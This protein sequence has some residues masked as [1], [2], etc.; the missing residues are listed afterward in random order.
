MPFLV[1]LVV[2]ILPLFALGLSNHGLWTPDEPRVGEIGREMALSGDWAVPTLNKRPFLEEP[3]FYYASLAVTFKL[4]GAVSDR[5]A[6]MPS[7]LF[8]FGGVVAL[9]FLGSM[10]FNPR[11]GFL[12]GFVLATGGE[13][14]RVAHWLVVDSAL[15]CFVIAAMAFFMAGYRSG[16]PGKRLLSYILCYI[17]CTLAFYSKGFIGIAIPGLAVLAFII[18]DRNLKELLRMQLWLG[19]LVFAAMVLPW[20]VAL[21]HQGGAEHLRVYLIH[22]HLQRFLS[23]GTSG[24]HQP[25][26]YYLTEFPAGFLPWSLLLVPV[27]YFCI[28]RPKKEAA[29]YQQGLLFAGCW[30][31][32]GFVFLSLASTKRV[33]YLMPVF[34][35]IAMLT[36]CYIDITLASRTFRKVEK[37]FLWA[38]GCLPLLVGLMCVPLYLYAAKLYAVGSSRA[39]L[40]AVISVSV[41]AVLCSLVSLRALVKRQM[42]SFWICSDAALF[43]LLIFALVVAVPLLDRY[44]SLVPFCQQVKRAVATDAAL[45]AY[46]PDETLRG[47]LPFYTGYHPKE[48]EDSK[49]LEDILAGGSQVYVAI[50]DSHQRLEKELLSTGRFMVLRRQDMGTDRS[51]VLLTNKP[52]GEGSWGKGHGS[53][54]NQTTK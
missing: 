30:F 28:E 15:T 37:V 43:S 29:G 12:S 13:Y 26:Y 38:F 47:A 17:S 44:K 24:H 54:V 40:A 41:L 6:R 10:L 50:R 1:L 5:V 51:L 8:A 49:G 45:Y 53:R 16:K 9:F 19:I 36:A 18:F 23:G 7:A 35:P 48:I 21:W 31:L 14:F 27:V 25:F 46:Q 52:I 3:P 2:T 32:T 42:A 4:L 20:F 39:L 33:L 34:A 22:N 11:V